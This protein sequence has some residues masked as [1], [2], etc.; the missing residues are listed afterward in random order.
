[1]K[2]I[3]VIHFNVYGVDVAF[4]NNNDMA[5]LSPTM[6]RGNNPVNS[7]NTTEII[8]SPKAINDHTFERF[9]PV[10]QAMTVNNTMTARNANV[11]R[12]FLA[13]KSV[14]MNN[15]TAKATSP[16][17]NT[18]YKTFNCDWIRSCSSPSSIFKRK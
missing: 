18:G 5:G 12:G 3:I 14:K 16:T 2:A 9:K 10:T 1:M 6:T 11:I 15:V 17:N 4:F 8:V 7:N 13:K